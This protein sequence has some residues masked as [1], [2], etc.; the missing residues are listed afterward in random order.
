M[1]AKK[2][3]LGCG[4]KIIKGFVNIDLRPVDKNVHVDNVATLETIQ[5]NSVDLIYACHVLEHFGRHEIH[6]VLQCWYNKLKIGGVLRLSVPDL[7]KVASLYSGGAYSLDKM[8]GF[9]YGGQNH[10]FD[11]HK[12][13]FDTE[14]LRESLWK[15][16]FREFAPW[17]WRETEHAKYDDFSQAYLPHMNK[18]DGLLMSVNLEAIKCVL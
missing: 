12:M 7:R 16:G 11:Y 9:L 4:L 10:D 17:D 3:H 15:V 6:D 14:T 13:G 18:E 1:S 5:D 8:Y 2:L